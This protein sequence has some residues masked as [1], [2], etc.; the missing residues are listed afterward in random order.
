MSNARG[1]MLYAAL[2]RS[3]C[4]LRVTCGEGTADVRALCVV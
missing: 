1:Q 2:S 3:A 4:E